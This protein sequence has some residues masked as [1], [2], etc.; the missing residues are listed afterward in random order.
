MGTIL[1]CLYGKAQN[2]HW[3]SSRP[4]GHAPIS[5]MGDHYHKKGEIMISYRYMRMQMEGNLSGSDDI[6]NETIFQDFAIAPQEMQMSMHMLG[7]MYAPTN[8]LT[9]MLMGTYINNSMDLRTRMGIDFNTGSG[10]FG[11]ISMAGLVKILNRNRQSLH[12]TVGISIPTGNIDQRDNTPTATNAPLAYPMQLGSGTFD[13]FL[14]ATYLGQSDLFSW[15]IQSTYKL[16][17]GNNSEGYS[18]G[19]QFD[20]SGWGAIKVSDYVSFSTSL[21]YFDLEKID[22]VDPDFNPMMMPLLN[23]DNSGR[24]QLDL[25]IGSNLLVP[26]GSIK[27]LRLALEI[28]FPVTQNTYGTQMKNQW[29]GTFG[30]QYSIGHHKKHIEEE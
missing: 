25:G 13:P 20:A 12:T 1:L 17:M 9:L 26:N 22:G 21:N 23:T 29:M 24:S 5:I 6:N 11:D 16:R 27:N 14:G 4:D 19:N 8:R 3:T 28:K 15:G 10:G 7:A 18:F 30:I 2:N